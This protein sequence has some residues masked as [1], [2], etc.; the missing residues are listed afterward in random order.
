MCDLGLHI[1]GMPLCCTRSLFVFPLTI[2]SPKALLACRARLYELIVNC[3]PGDVILKR[4]LFALVAPTSGVGESLQHD[5][6]VWAAHY[7]HR[8]NVSR[9]ER[10]VSR[11]RLLTP[12]LA[13]SVSRLATRS[14]S[15]SRRSLQKPCCSSSQM[16]PCGRCRQL[17][18]QAPARSHFVNVLTGC[19][20]AP[21]TLL[22][23]VFS[24]GSRR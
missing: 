14:S 15:T 13:L 16:W 21:L 11:A 24:R 19:M 1:L 12:C 22:L 2:C 23:I 20:S 9:G 4:L 18:L 7:E 5:L 8:L 3:I 17:R 6:T 10:C